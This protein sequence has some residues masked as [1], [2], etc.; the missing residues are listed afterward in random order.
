MAGSADAVPQGIIESLSRPGGNVTGLTALSSELAPK[1]L[2][3]LKD[4]QPRIKNVA[5]LWCP[6]SQISRLELG[7]VQAASKAQQVDIQVVH[8]D[9][10]PK[11][12][13]D[14]RELLERSR[15][16]ALFLLDCTNLPF[17]A[18]V[19][20]SLQRR[21]PTMSPYSVVTRL[22]ALVSYGPD[23]ASMAR[24]AA[25]Y[26][27][28]LLKG[29]KPADLPV[30]QPTKFELVINSKTAKALGLTIP[31]SLLMRADEVVQ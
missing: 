24:G 7:N 3:L 29:A 8:Y 14:A 18:I 17:Q 15:P 13:N 5:V 6:P 12:W 23:F 28:K 25:N 9:G 11:S 22:G 10:T 21:L 20:F 26:V 27:D 31:Q 30:E 2:E 16:D 4:L 1:R 19:D